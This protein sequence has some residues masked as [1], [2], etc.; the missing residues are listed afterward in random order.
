MSLNMTK[1]GQLY[2]VSLPI[3]FMATLKSEKSKTEG[4]YLQFI[5]VA[6]MTY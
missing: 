2:L 5:I 6:N 1:R 3:N 4:Q